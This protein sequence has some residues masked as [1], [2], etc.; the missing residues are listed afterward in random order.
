MRASLADVLV[1][2]QDIRVIEVLLGKYRVCHTTT[3]NSLAGQTRRGES[4]QISIR[5]C[6]KSFT[7]ERKFVYTLLWGGHH[8]YKL[9]VECI[10]LYNKRYKELNI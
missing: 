5:L 10:A 2:R 4:G 3:T 1:V 9:M 6:C 7:V 8:A